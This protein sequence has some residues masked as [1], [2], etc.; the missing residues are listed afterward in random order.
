M[1]CV[2]KI[3]C[4]SR[5]YR[6]G[7]EVQPDFED[8]DAA[9]QRVLPGC[10]AADATFG[11]DGEAHPLTPDAFEAFLATGRELA[12]GQVVLRLGVSKLCDELPS[13]TRPTLLQSAAPAKAAKLAKSRAR[14]ASWAEDERPLDELVAGL[15]EVPKKGPQRHSKKK[16]ARNSTSP[17]G[18]QGADGDPAQAGDDPLAPGRRDPD[19]D[20][21]EERGGSAKPA[22]VVS[23]GALDADPG[24]GAID[25][26]PGA[27]DPG[28][29]R[30]ESAGER[31]GSAGTAVVSTGAFEE[32]P[33]EDARSA[34]LALEDSAAELA[35]ED[36]DEDA[37]IGLGPPLPKGLRRSSSCPAWALPALAAGAEAP[38][39]LPP[40]PSEVW[41]PTPDS[42]PPH[43]PRLGCQVHW[44]AAAD[45]LAQ[46][47]FVW[48]PVLLPVF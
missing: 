3:S 26:G 7:L 20:R 21:G 47:Q 44:P 31:G 16:G 12:S 18:A 48:V 1:A 9:V 28:A 6:V 45:L 25:L 23:M 4:G 46:Q 30:G 17:S 38:R 11:G 19:A 40:E 39:E 8:V 37:I 36:P 24:K 42:T 22:A 2:L 15:Q 29:V 10:G 41:P 5:I 32:D 14:G 13:A 35:F 43:S 27:R 33:G 34:E